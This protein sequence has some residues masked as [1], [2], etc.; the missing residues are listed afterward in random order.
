MGADP[1][2]SFDAVADEYDRLRPS[3]P[4][5]LYADLLEA[6]ALPAGARVLE[7]G[8]GSGIA[9]LPFARRGFRSTSPTSG[10]SIS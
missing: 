8:A 4:D 10:R 6:V 1:A 3:Y 5:A 9:S 7:I 2:H